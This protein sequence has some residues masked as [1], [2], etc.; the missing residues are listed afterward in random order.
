MNVNNVTLAHVAVGKKAYPAD[1]LPEVAFA[2][3]S[4]VG[5]SSLINAMVNRK[6]LARSSGS[7]GKTRTINFYLVEDAL[8]F[9]DLPGYG[10]A[11]VKRTEVSR[12]GR[13]TENYVTARHTLKAVVL[14]ADIRREPNDNDMIMLG[15]MRGNGFP[16]IIAATKADKLKRSELNARLNAIKSA[17][18][19]INGDVMIPFSS[20]TKAGKDELWEAIERVTGV[21]S[22]LPVPGGR[23]IRDI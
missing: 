15:F 12:M 1:G 10:Y 2:G 11:K 16:V 3:R 21:G 18:G 14:V 4:N 19:L 20:E 9:V 6:S 23:L 5:K 13:M 22:R 17:F 8:Y 7:P